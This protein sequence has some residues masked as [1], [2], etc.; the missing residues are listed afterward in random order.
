MYLGIDFGLKRVGLAIAPPDGP[1]APLAVIAWGAG[2]AFRD[3]TSLIVEI[4][5]IAT[6]ERMETIVVGLPQSESQSRPAVDEFIV[7]LRQA[8]RLPIET[9]DE[10]MST[11]LADRLTGYRGVAE[12][13]AVAAAVILQGYL[14]SLP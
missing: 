14:D 1:A 3:R 5:R 12:P 10:R 11:K 6:S 13:D 9:T 7:E 4:V 2:S 8:T